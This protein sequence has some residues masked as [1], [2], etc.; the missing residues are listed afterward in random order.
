MLLFFRRVMR[1][2]IER[3]KW[4]EQSNSITQSCRSRRSSTRSPPSLSAIWQKTATSSLWTTQKFLPAAFRFINIWDLKY[5]FTMVWHK[6]GGY[7][8]MG[9]AQYNCEFVVYARKGSP[10]FIETR[11]FPTCFEATRR[12]HS[13]N[14]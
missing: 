1:S 10:Q 11:A 8:P 5:V 6:P 9:L 14:P 12:S 2:K 4:L 7:Q 3:D 13:E